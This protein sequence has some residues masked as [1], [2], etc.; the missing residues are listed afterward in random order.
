MSLFSI[1]GKASGSF[2]LLRNRP[3]K[4]PS[5]LFPTP[6]GARRR[7]DVEIVFTLTLKLNR[8]TKGEEAKQQGKGKATRNSS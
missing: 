3:N 1:L 7:N 8:F 2:S 5:L 4:H 6:F